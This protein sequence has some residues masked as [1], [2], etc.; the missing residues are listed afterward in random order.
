MDLDEYFSFGAGGPYRRHEVFTDR[1]EYTQLL[2]DRAD[3]LARQR[4]SA[5]D[6]Q[7]FARPARN[8]VVI[9]G[10]GGVGKTTLVNRFCSL[11]TDD[12]RAAPRRMIVSFDF[13]D[14]SNLS[15]ETVV[16]RLRAALGRL[17]RQFTAFDTCLAVYWELK[18]PGVGLSEF[19]GRSGFLSREDREETARQIAGVIDEVLGSLAVVELGYR[20]A[21]GLATRIRDAAAVRRMRREFPPFDVILGETNPDQM[22]GYLPI[23]L[24]WDIEQIRAKQPAVAVCHLDTFEAVQALPREHGLLEDLLARTAYL[25]PNALFVVTSRRPLRWHDPIRAVTL[26]YGGHD[27]WPRLGG[28]HGVSDQYSLDGLDPPYADAFLRE[29]LT[30]DDGTPAIDEQVRRRIADASGGSP[31]YL[32]L[33]V[34][35]YRNALMRGQHPAPEDFGGPL[36]QLVLRIMR[37]LSAT[38]RELLRAAS[39]LEAFDAGLLRVVLP[40]VSMVAIERFLANSFVRYAAGTWPQ[41]RIHQ[42]LRQ[43]INACDE[44]TDDAW[45][46]SERAERAERAIARAATVGLQ[47]WEPDESDT[48]EVAQ[49]SQSAVA[50]LLLVLHAAIEHDLLPEQLRDLTYTVSQLGHWQVLAALPAAPSAE[51]PLHRLVEA[52]RLTSTAAV[53]ARVRY[54]QL[55]ALDQTPWEHP[56][57]GYVAYELGAM[58]QSTGDHADGDAHFAALAEGGPLLRQAGAWGRAGVALRRSRLGDV[59]AYA[60]PSGQVLEDTRTWDLLGHVYLHGGDFVRSAE[61]FRR[62]L[63]HARRAGAPLWGAR[64]ARHLALATMWFDPAAAAAALPGAR[65]LNQGLGDLIGLAQCDLAAAVWAVAQGDVAAADALLASARDLT[66]RSGVVG[67]LLPVEAVAVLVT[68]ASGRPEPAREAAAALAA[69]ARGDQLMPPVWAAVAALWLDEPD[70]YEFAAVG[71][72]DGADAARERWRQPLRTLTAAART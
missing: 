32:E 19:V 37:D 60:E 46:R 31:L 62:T 3:A 29:R 6:L 43:S 1:E 67:Q 69:D 56:Y 5:D 8:V 11:L 28:Q 63:D 58:T 72:Y 4:L 30:H 64:A 20:A 53:D 40:E 12:D 70:L 54:R 57:D 65:E 17:G 55:K 51:S 68:L 38:E 27:R 66:H 45:A 25:M 49:R 9:H 22:L 14:S 13:A 34:S 33:S 26:T 24:A 42:N 47:V 59:L 52:A 15:F 50:A 2:L 18:H 23:L 10:Q 7:D 21:R 71:W 61:H 35:Q 39:L 41:Y 16:L 36:P 48:V 44:F